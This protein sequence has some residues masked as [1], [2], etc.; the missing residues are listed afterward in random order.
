MSPGTPSW[1]PNGTPLVTVRA[2]PLLMTGVEAQGRPSGSGRGRARTLA[3]CWL[4]APHRRSTPA[5]AP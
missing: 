4:A 2:R 3:G 5:P 1:T